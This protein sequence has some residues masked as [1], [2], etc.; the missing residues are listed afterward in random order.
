MEL[1]YLKTLGRAR[2]SLRQASSP[3]G[4]VAQS[5][6][7]SSIEFMKQLLD[8]DNRNANGSLSQSLSFN[9]ESNNSEISVEFLANDYWDFINSGVNGVERSFGSPY[10]FRSLNPSPAMLDSLT[11]TGSLRGWMA[12]RGIRS[13]SYIDKE[14]NN[15]NKQLST[16]SDFRQ[17][18]WV[19]AR[20]IKRNGIRPTEFLDDT[21]NEDSLLKFEDDIFEAFNSLL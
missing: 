7:S 13:L 12:A 8:D 9:I 17:A 19:F 6:A 20:A 10:S 14:G 3:V 1:E 16:D 18:A 5:F 4:V 15:I 11:G 2:E 21:F